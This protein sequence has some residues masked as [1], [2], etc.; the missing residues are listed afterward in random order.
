MRFANKVVLV[1]G[2]SQGIGEAMCRRFAAEGAKVA[3]VASSSIEKA[4]GVVDAIVGAGGEARPFRCDVTSVEQIQTLVESVLHSFGQI[5]VLVNS[6]GIF[7][8]T[9][10]GHTDEAMFDRMCDINLKGT[11]FMCNA[12][13]PHMQ[14]RGSGKIINMGSTSGVIGRRDFIV[15]SATKAAVI[16]MTR[17]LA[18]ALA[19][20]G[21]NVNVIAPGNTETPMNEGIRKNPENAGIRA[22]IAERTPSKRLF[23]DPNEIAGAALFLASDDAQAMFGSMVLMDQ[24]I[25]AGY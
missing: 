25:T 8:P 7:Y 22:T 2:G 10:I 12:V 23:A 24:G 1:T 4:Q 18:V 5:D 15:Y 13:A 11:F 21:V 6:A 17:A 3:V 16:H 9:R 14:E 19:P 20:H